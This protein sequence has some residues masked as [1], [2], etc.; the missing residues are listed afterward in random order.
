MNEQQFWNLIDL[1]L[2]SSESYEDLKKNLCQFGKDE[3]I[4]FKRILMEKL[5][6]SCSF[7]LLAANFVISSYVSDDGFK[8][9]RAWLIS[10]GESKF[11]DA[12][13]NPETIAKWLKKDDVDEIDGGALLI[14]ADDAYEEAG[15]DLND[16]MEK[17]GRYPDPKINMDWPENKAEYE[18]RYPI[19]VKH[20]W[21]Q[22]R[23]REF[24]S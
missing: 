17:V 18:N 9:F 22:G 11:L 21:N 12:V 3:I 4:S 13:R 7:P 14:V 19:L 2:N 15:G 10:K 1:H 8:E 16:F 20:F 6:Q 23:I 5:V 24:H